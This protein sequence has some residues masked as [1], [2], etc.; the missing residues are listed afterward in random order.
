MMLMLLFPQQFYYLLK[1]NN[2]LHCNILLSFLIIKLGDQNCS[3][4]YLNIQLFLFFKRDVCRVQRSFIL[5]EPFPQTLFSPLV[6]LW[7]CLLFFPSWFYSQWK[8]F[9]KDNFQ[10][11]GKM[12]HIFFWFSFGCSFDHIFLT[13]F[14]FDH[15]LDQLRKH[16]CSPIDKLSMI[17]FLNHHNRLIIKILYLII[18]INNGQDGNYL[19]GIF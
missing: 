9:L 14:P 4:G 5:D 8:S 7:L 19:I 13:L 16:N 17:C 2:A 1:I 15:L 12:T 18:L 11:Y 6:L 10:H 3:Y